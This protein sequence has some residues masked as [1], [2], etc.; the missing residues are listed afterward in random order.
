MTKRPTLTTSVGAPIGD[1]QNSV[2][3]GQHGPVLL[4]DYRLIETLAHQNRE[5]I[6]ERTVRANAGA[7]RSTSTVTYD[8]TKFA[9]AKTFSEVG[10]IRMLACFSAVAGELGAAD[11]ERIPAFQYSPASGP[12]RLRH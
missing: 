10:K 3:A 8:I 11:A 9:K 1:N 4:Q 2:T 7:P 6:P 5:R 12:R